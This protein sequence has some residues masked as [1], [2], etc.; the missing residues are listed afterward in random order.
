MVGQSSQKEI[1]ILVHEFLKPLNANRYKVLF[2]ENIIFQMIN[3]WYDVRV[4]TWLGDQEIASLNVHPNQTVYS[5][6]MKIS[7][8]VQKSPKDINLI[9]H[10]V[11]LRNQL[12]FEQ[13]DIAINDILHSCWVGQRKSL[14]CAL[15]REKNIDR[16][17]DK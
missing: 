8:I 12:T 16:F 4:R 2:L 17:L 7:Q 14:D 6:K 10:G 15:Q 1:K 3:L 11:L 13:E 9:R 5:I